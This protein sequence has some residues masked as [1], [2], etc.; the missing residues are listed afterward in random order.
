[1][2]AFL[3]PIIQGPTK[4][5]GLRFNFDKTKAIDL[6]PGSYVV[7][8]GL[9]LKQAALAGLGIMLTPEIF[10]EEEIQAG[11]LITLLPEWNVERQALYAIYPYHKEQSIKVRAFIDFLI[12][13]FSK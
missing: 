10:V 3:F 4:W 7:N 8:N 6:A 1:M 9:A 5:I 12:A 11:K 13:Y 2:K